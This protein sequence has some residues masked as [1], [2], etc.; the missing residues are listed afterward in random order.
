MTYH[1]SL[2]LIVYAIL[3]ILG[4]VADLLDIGASAN[5]SA[6]LNRGGRS[7]EDGWPRQEER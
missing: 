2:L 7:R 1:A 6:H 5:G 4:Y 3:L